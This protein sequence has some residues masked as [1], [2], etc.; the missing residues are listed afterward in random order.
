MSTE[1]IESI[2]AQLV[3]TGVGD[4]QFW[5][6]WETFPPDQ[7]AAS[8]KAALL[9]TAARPADVLGL[10]ETILMRRRQGGRGGVGAGERH[11][12]GAGSE[13]SALMAYVTSATYAPWLPL[14]ESMSMDTGRR[15]CAHRVPPCEISTTS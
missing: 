14:G 1:D 7:K 6:D 2:R 9:M 8:L 11:R 4:R 13:G 3:A 10:I 12:R 5:V 15:T